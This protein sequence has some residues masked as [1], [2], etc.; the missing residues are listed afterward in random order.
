LLITCTVGASRGTTLADSNLQVIV[1]G[2]F[3]KCQIIFA[4]Q[5]VLLAEFAGSFVVRWTYHAIWI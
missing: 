2:T 5:R 3:I 1:G 4:D